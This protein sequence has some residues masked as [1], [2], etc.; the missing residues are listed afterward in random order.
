MYT[1][2]EKAKADGNMYRECPNTVLVIASI[3]IATGGRATSA[4]S[5]DSDGGSKFHGACYFET[6][7]PPLM[8]LNGKSMV[9]K[10]DV[11]AGDGAT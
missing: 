10:W 9:Y 8:S 3:G 7:T 5:T 1:Y 6:T 2:Y 11:E 4:G